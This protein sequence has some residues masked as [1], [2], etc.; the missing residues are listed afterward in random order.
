MEAINLIMIMIITIMKIKIIIIII[1]IIIVVVVILKGIRIIS[2]KCYAPR[3]N[4]S[5]KN[6]LE[7]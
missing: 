2:G 7:S 4:Y 5:M 3:L 6:L 1:L